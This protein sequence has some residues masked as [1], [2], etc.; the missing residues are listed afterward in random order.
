MALADLPA[1]APT[2]MPYRLSGPDD[3]VETARQVEAAGA[4]ALVVPT[5][6][7]R[8]DEVARLVD[9]VVGELGRLDVLVANAGI[10]AAVP[11]DAVT[12][13]R[14]E[15]MLATNLSGV[16]H[17]LRSAAPH[18]R[19]QG[20]G[21]IVVVASMAARRGMANLT[22]Y[23]ATKFGLVGLAKAAAL[24]L[25]ADGVTVHVLC[26]TTV[27]T[28]MIHYPENY[29]VFCPDVIEPGR[30]EAA[31]QFARLNPMGVP[32]LAPEDVA[33]VMLQVVLSGTYQSGAVIE[34]G[35]GT[36]AMLP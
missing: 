20:R 2:S 18:M 11:L 34:I 33:Q 27:D 3:L 15:D 31:G 19:A 28:P 6:V 21:R 4:R 16:F 24:E 22:H 8:P 32:W 26:P 5:D 13:E 14:W 35:A 36:S 7:R 29:A 12:D 17:C 23:C 9:Q 10:C 25:L 30:D 1:G